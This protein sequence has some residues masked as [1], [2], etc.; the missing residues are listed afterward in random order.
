MLRL[1]D[2]VAI[3]IF[4][5][6]TQEQ[7]RNAVDLSDLMDVIIVD[8]SIGVINKIPGRESIVTY[9][10]LIVNKGIAYAQNVGIEIAIEKGY[11]YILFKDQDSTFDNE[12]ILALYE[13]YKAVSALDHN[14]AAMGPVIINNAQ[15][16]EYKNTLNKDDI[17]KQ[18]ST[19]ISSGMLTESEKLM[20]IGFMEKELFIDNVDHEWC[21][22]AM[23]NGFSIYMTRKSVLYHSVGSS[24]KRILDMQIIKS[25]PFRSYYKYRNNIWLIKR[26]YVPNLWKVK[27][28]INMLLQYVIYIVCFKEYGLEYLKHASKGIKDGI[29]L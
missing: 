22:R 25:A 18:V 15:G 7:I 23:A 13:E 26:K 19:I 28:L 5:N 11:K 24:T 20:Q 1:N 3:V 2:T 12:S 14:I 17:T 4:Y 16:K 9:I 6:P 27:T 21:W 8:N 29:I 10:P